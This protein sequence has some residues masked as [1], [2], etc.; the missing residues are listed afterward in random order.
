M[1]ASIGQPLISAEIQVAAR[2]RRGRA[3]TEMT[4]WPI[5]GLT[6]IA[7]AGSAA[8]NM[9]EPLVDAAVRQSGAL[10]LRIVIGENNADLAL[11]LALLLGAEPDMLCVATAASASAVLAAVDEHS[12]NAF[13]LDLSLD[14][15]PSLPLISLLRGR[16]PTAVI[17]VFTG[18]KNELL[19]E[20][21]LKAGA[22]A[23]VVKAGEFEELTAALRRA[24]QA[25][26]ARAIGAP[27]PG[28]SGVSADG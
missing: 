24:A 11:T 7:T 22:D 19:K 6:P 8:A 12:P 14:D 17:V 20:H 13:I 18:H 10:S 26:A 5:I 1:P 21:C 25:G 27:S 2:R 15:G 9:A 23:L 28:G 3:F 4:R 16:L